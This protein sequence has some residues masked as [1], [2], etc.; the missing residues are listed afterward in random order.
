MNAPVRNL[1]RMKTRIR[2]LRKERG[3]TQ[4]GLAV[5]ADVHQPQISLLEKGDSNTT[6][7]TLEAVAAALKVQVID[8]FE[9]EEE[10]PTAKELLQKFQRLSDDEQALLVHTADVILAGRRQ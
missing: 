5:A 1:T 3:Y 7:K 10:A 9:P 2:E 6:I 4:E 8:L